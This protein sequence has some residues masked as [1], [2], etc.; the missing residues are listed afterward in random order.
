MCVYVC[1]CINIICRRGIF[2]HKDFNHFFLIN[3]GQNV[4]YKIKRNGKLWT[5]N[6]E[7]RGDIEQ[8]HHF[9]FS[10]C[11]L[12]LFSVDLSDTRRTEIAAG[13]TILSSKIFSAQNIFFRLF[14]E[15]AVEIY[16][17]VNIIFWCCF[18]FIL[19]HTIFI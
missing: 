14:I 16:Q 19:W 1:V 8:I 4:K 5:W 18:I 6:I 9:Y 3:F 17:V 10:V 2:Q 7:C 13:I 11:Q 12:E 15:I